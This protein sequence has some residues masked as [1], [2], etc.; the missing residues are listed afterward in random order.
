MKV[1][2]EQIESHENEK[3]FVIR[4]KEIDEDVLQIKKLIE[5]YG[6]RLEGKL[7]HE[8]FFIRLPDIY[9]FE[10]VEY[11]V[12][13]YTR[14]LVYKVAYSLERLEALYSKDGFF[15]CAKAMLVNLEHVEK[16]KSII[17][18]KIVATLD[19]KEEII[20]SRHYSKLL[21]AYLKAE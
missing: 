1:I 20:I 13:A 12:Y 4:C 2:I 14:D 18:N 19:N 16:L 21:R 8:S 17:G 9:Y 3:E 11:Y 15:R 10:Y 7:N 6:I 5:A